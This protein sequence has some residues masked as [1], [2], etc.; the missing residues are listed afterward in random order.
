M[1]NIRTDITVGDIVQHFK[2]ETLSHPGNLYLYKILAFAEHTETK[3]ML[4]I[5]QAL[6]K[7]PSKNIDYT[8]FARPMD[9]FMSE[10]EHDK[11]PDIKQ[12]YRF[13][14]YTGEYT[15]DE[16][17]KSSVYV[18]KY[19]D[20][21]DHDHT[22]FILGVAS[23]YERAIEMIKDEIKNIACCYHSYRFSIE[24]W[25]LDRRYMGG[26]TESFTKEKNI[27]F[28]KELGVYQEE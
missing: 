15:S 25:E 12:K 28:A 26:L 4:V 13:E 21:Y 11:Y 16:H 5:Y 27:E 10:V 23:I 22:E 8:I 14:K 9:M 24:Q 7:D 19:Y 3:A 17:V 18:V 6:Y 2:R 1:D 20:I